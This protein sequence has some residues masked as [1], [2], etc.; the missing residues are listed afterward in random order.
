MIFC[1]CSDHYEDEV[2]DERR[3]QQELDHEIRALEIKLRRQ[4]QKTGDVK[5]ASK[6][7]K[8]LIQKN[9]VTTGNRLDQV[10]CVLWSAGQCAGLTCVSR[11]LSIIWRFI[12]Y[13]RLS[14][15]PDHTLPSLIATLDYL[16]LDYSPS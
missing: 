7:R 10:M 1:V 13:S 15:T 3:H 8:I 12:R 4:H 6:Q 2:A 11:L 9:L 16:L 5:D 14:T